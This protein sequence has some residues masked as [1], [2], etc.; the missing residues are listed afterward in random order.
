MYSESF[1]TY[2]QTPQPLIS[3]IISAYNKAPY[4]TETIQSL[5]AQN[6]SNLEILVVDDGSTD[7][8]TQLV[9][10]LPGTFPN[11]KICTFHKQN[12]G[13]SDAR[14][15]LIERCTGRIVLS[16]DADDLVAPGFIDDALAAMRRE[17]ANL[18]YTDVEVFGGDSSEWCPPAYDPYYVRYNNCVP[19]LVLYDKQLWISS[20][21]YNKAIPFNEDWSFFI[22]LQLVGVN[23]YKLSK[24]YFRYRY[25][26]TGFF[27]SCIK[28]ERK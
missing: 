21:G 9:D 27:H 10:S 7:G 17:R 2:L 12:G 6:Y 3:V 23:A 18:I 28:D 22:N 24:K 15:Y 20:G 1:E 8:T 16:V 11:L 4:L 13:V 14:N 19:S 5:A 25:T 26:K